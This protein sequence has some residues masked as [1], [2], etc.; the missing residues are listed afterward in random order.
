[1]ALLPSGNERLV[2][3][4][5]VSW[6]RWRSLAR[7]RGGNLFPSFCRRR[8]LRRPC[9]RRWDGG[10]GRR[11]RV[12]GRDRN[13]RV[14]RPQGRQRQSSSKLRRDRPL[15]GERA[16]DT[17]DEPVQPLWRARKDS[18]YRLAHEVNLEPVS[19]RIVLEE[20]NSVVIIRTRV[21][22]DLAAPRASRGDVHRYSLYG[23]P[24]PSL[25]A[26]IRRERSERKV[27]WQFM[28]GDTRRNG[29]RRG[30]RSAPCGQLSVPHPPACS[31]QSEHHSHYGREKLAHLPLPLRTLYCRRTHSQERHNEQNRT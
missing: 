9:R 8:R 30:R 16:L 13:G 5:F 14:A 28:A 1:M 23:N 20:D 7:L 18:R 21:N 12:Q 17:M 2:F 3:A 19:R 27:H 15:A 22:A 11:F 6:A 4:R 29:R 31:C 25:S 10:P 24:V 26:H